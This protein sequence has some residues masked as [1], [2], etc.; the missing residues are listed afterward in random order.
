MSFRY[1]LFFTKIII[2]HSTTIFQKNLFY[3]SLLQNVD[4][5]HQRL[6]DNF[7]NHTQ[8]LKHKCFLENYFAK[9]LYYIIIL[10][11]FNRSWN[12][13]LLNTTDDNIVWMLKI[14]RVLAFDSPKGLPNF[15]HCMSTKQ[16][17]FLPVP[18]LAVIIKGKFSF[19]VN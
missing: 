19:Y 16:M 12:D 14:I 18:F 5:K 4:S 11:L 2:P 7:E 15:N 13:K 6:D 9:Q 3:S 10:V 8:I 17:I 1:F